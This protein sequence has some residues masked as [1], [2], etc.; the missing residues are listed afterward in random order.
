MLLLSVDGLH[1]SDLDW[2]VTTHPRSL[3]AALTRRGTSY[4]HVKTPAPFDSFPGL[5][6]LVTGGNPRSTGLYYDI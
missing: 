1:Q 4:T 2:Y 6:A 3:L 5:A